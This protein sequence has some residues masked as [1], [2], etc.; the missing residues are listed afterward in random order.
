M[1]QKCPSKQ[2]VGR[3]GWI[4]EWWSYD[5][6][7]PSFRENINIQQV[8]LWRSF[9][10]GQS[11]THKDGGSLAWRIVL[12]NTR[13]NDHDGFWSVIW[14][15]WVY[16]WIWTGRKYL[17]YPATPGWT[18]LTENE[19]RVMRKATD[20]DGLMCWSCSSSMLHLP[21]PS[22]AA[23]GDGFTTHSRILHTYAAL[24]CR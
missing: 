22:R 2:L 1:G 21:L 19:I 20:P 5:P 6:P 3:N 10:K 11:L 7:Y 18:C 4:L 14:K 12:C 23:Q 15:D 17:I 13:L 8:Q 24:A 9:A 16:F